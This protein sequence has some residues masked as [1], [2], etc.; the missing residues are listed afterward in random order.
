MK[1][2]F[3]LENVYACLSLRFTFFYIN[4]VLTTFIKVSGVTSITHSSTFPAIAGASAEG[5]GEDKSFISTSRIK[6][7]KPYANVMT[8]HISIYRWSALKEGSAR[9]RKEAD[10]AKLSYFNI[11]ETGRRRERNFISFNYHSALTDSPQSSQLRRTQ[12]RL[13]DVLNES[14]ISSTFLGIRRSD[15]D[16]TGGRVRLRRRNRPVMELFSFLSTFNIKFIRVWAEKAWSLFN[17]DLNIIFQE[18]LLLFNFPSL[19]KIILNFPLSSTTSSL[20]LI[21]AGEIIEKQIGLLGISGKLPLNNED[22]I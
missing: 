20:V 19:K 1:S 3:A 5:N 14:Q 6:F 21:N 12:L 10:K 18:E 8:F 16:A 15:G 7:I 22:E 9:I 4:L 11:S 17:K 13:V 2:F